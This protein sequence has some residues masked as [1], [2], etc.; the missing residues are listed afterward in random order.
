MEQVDF[1][2]RLR[3]LISQ[4]GND[5]G[6]NLVAVGV[7]VAVLLLFLVAVRFLKRWLFAHAAGPAQETGVIE[8]DLADFPPPPAGTKRL[9]IEGRPVRLR[10]VVVA[11]V[12]RD[13]AV[14]ISQIETLLDQIVYGLGTIA[15]Q[16]KPRVRAWPPQLSNKSFAVT[17]N[18]MV[19]RPEKPGQPSRW[20]LVAGQTPPRPR[21]VML[22]L[23]LLADEPN[24]VGN[25]TLT[26]EQWS[27]TLRV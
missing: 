6:V 3:N 16:D 24:A 20:I 23:A 7:G 26:S 19:R 13:A 17:F 4:A 1:L 21:Q 27:A 25:L 12:G 18:R 8:E 14:D 10:L 5:S 22:G 15:R 2:Q 11:A 9:M